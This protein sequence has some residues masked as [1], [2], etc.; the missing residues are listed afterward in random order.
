MY[1]L[2]N[3]GDRPHPCLTPLCMC[4]G[5]DIASLT[6]AHVYIYI[7][8]YIYIY[9]YTYNLR[10]PKFTLKRLKRSY[11]FRSHDHKPGAYIV[12]C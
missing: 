6:H 2:N 12:P 7:Y 11:M 3:T 5:S 1:M 9:M 8:I 10:S 4:T